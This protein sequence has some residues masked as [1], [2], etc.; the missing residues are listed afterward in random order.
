MTWDKL[1]LTKLYNEDRMTLREI[2]AHF[3]VSHERIR[4]VMQRLGVDMARKRTHK[5]RLRPLGLK[6]KTLDEYLMNSAQ[7][8][9]GGAIAARTVRKYLPVTVCCAECHRKIGQDSAHVHHIVYPAWSSDDIQTLCPS[10]HKIQ[11]CGRMTLA[12]QWSV[13]SEY[14]SGESISSLIGKYQVSRSTIWRVIHKISAGL[15]IIHEDRRKP[16]NIEQ[17]SI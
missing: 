15:P 4:Q 13:Y 9:R 5:Y 11:H 12:K 14:A 7:Y 6:F 10:C 3:G 16:A 2:G 8:N 17:D 1:E